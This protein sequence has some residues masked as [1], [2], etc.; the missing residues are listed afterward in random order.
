MM[1]VVAEKIKYG[2]GPSMPRGS[3]LDAPSVLRWSA[4]FLSYVHYIRGPDRNGNPGP[5]SGLSS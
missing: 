5:R 1:G 2:W 4:T 3:Y